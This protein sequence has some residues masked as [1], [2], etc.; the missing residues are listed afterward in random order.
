MSNIINLSGGKDST[1]MLHWMLEKGEDI[2]SVV[3]FDTGWEFPEMYDHLDQIERNT[4]IEII[5]LKPK[6]SFDYWMFERKI[7]NKETGLVYKIGRGW[8]DVHSRWCTREK[9]NTLNKYHN[10]IKDTNKVINIGVAIDEYKRI[11]NKDL[12]YPLVEY[13]KTEKDVLNIVTNLDTLG[14]VFIKDLK[15][16]HA[17]V[18]LLSHYKTSEY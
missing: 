7:V 14:M 10:S 1:A 18:V 13:K 9:V 5:R 15:E 3:F 11:K 2:H 4:G 8:P 16:C 17:F 12:R 6:R